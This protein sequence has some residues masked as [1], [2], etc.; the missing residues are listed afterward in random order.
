MNIET[1]IYSLIVKPINEDIF[2]EHATTICVADEAGG[3]FFTIEQEKGTLRFDFAEWPEV[4]AA[5]E[6][7]KEEWGA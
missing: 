4:C 2:S 5:V 3:V 7:L 6:R 1:K